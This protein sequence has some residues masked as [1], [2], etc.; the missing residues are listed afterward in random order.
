MSFIG[1]IHYGFA[2]AAYDT[3]RSEEETK[4]ISMQMFYSFVPAIMAFASTNFMLFSCPLTVKTVVFGFTS[5]MLT[6]LISLK[7]DHYCVSKEMAPIWFRKYKSNIFG[8]YM[9][10]TTVLF[11]IYFSKYNLI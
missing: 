7:F 8:L 6:Q 5:L 10:I 3:A 4:R 9:I 2:S 11:S 1:G